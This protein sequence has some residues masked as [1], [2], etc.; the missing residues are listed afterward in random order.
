[1]IKELLLEIRCEGYRYFQY[2]QWKVQ[3]PSA[4]G[5]ISLHIVWAIVI[6]ANMLDIAEQAYRRY[7]LEY[8]ERK[9]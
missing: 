3:K 8:F 4:K 6:S 5:D 2:T 1:M 9:E 7:P